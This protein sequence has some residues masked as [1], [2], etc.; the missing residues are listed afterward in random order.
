MFYANELNFICE[1]L[2]KCHVRGSVVLLDE[3]ISKVL[4]ESAEL[5]LDVPIS[6]GMSV[7]EWLGECEPCTMYKAI[8][9]FRQRYLYFELPEQ[10][11]RS[12]L[13]VG[14]YIHVVPAA[15]QVLELGEKNGVLPKNQKI[16]ESYYAN[17]PVL[18]ENSHIFIMLDVFCEQI[19]GTSRY[20][21]VD[22]EQE[23]HTSHFRINEAQSGEGLDGTLLSMKLME[24]RYDFENELMQA[25]TL[26]QENRASSLLVGF[27][28]RMFEKRVADSLR[29]VKNYCIIMNTL[30]RKAAER[31]GV[32]PIYLDKTSSSFALRLEQISSVSEVGAFMSEMFRSYCRLVR[33]YSARDYSPVVKN[34]VVAIDSELSTNLSLSTLAKAQKVSAGYLS[35]IFKKETGKTV[36]EYIRE[37]RIALAAQLLKTTHLQ[38]QTVALHCGIV[39]VQYF[40]KIFKKQVG[41]TPK[42]YRE[43]SRQTFSK[44]QAT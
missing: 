43:S 25:V 35:S 27:S 41:M 33:K 3:P 32:H 28:G 40:S 42:E 2:R 29:N 19:F 22:I 20:P 21:V 8:D 26:G 37:R 15:K 9:A 14:P 11:K 39:D 44:S 1:T 30:L 13:L 18:P 36:T 23:Q 17:L 6:E 12:V 34:A 16:F 4:G 38:I 10:E 7:G 31:G 5:M 24:Q